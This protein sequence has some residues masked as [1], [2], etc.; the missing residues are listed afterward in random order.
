MYQLILF[1]T[2][3][4]TIWSCPFIESKMHILLFLQSCCIANLN[5]N[6]SLVSLLDKAFNPVVDFLRI[7]L[8]HVYSLMKE[9]EKYSRSQWVK[10]DAAKASHMKKSETLRL[11]LQHIGRKC[12]GLHINI[13]Y[14]YHLT[15]RVVNHYDKVFIVT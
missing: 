14:Q 12:T 1:K 7:F 8:S 10:T 11:G 4:N 3:F 2:S 15:L 9:E 6:F 13:R 5:S